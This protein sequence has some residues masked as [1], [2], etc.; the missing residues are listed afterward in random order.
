VSYLLATCPECPVGLNSIGEFLY[1]LGIRSFLIGGYHTCESDEKKWSC[2]RQIM[3]RSLLKPLVALSILLNIT[4]SLPVLYGLTRPFVQYQIYHMLATRFGKQDLAFLGD[5]LTRNGG[6][7]AFKLGKYDFN[8]QNFGQGGLTTEGISCIAKAVAGPNYKTGLV[9]KYA[10]IMAGAND[11][12]RTAAGSKIS[13]RYYKEMLDALRQGGTEPVI[14][15]TLYREHDPCPEFV[16]TLN[17]QL[18]EYARTHNIAIIDLNPVLC[19][20]KSLLH[21]YSTDGLH[22]SGAAYEIWSAEIK[23]FLKQKKSAVK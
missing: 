9:W 6:V 15:L 4:V 14:Q 20:Q 7:W 1:A 10:F 3:K 5:S 11:T 22:L 2:E 16:D 23:R 18:R 17:D 12:P 19:A 21:V 8:T 13:F